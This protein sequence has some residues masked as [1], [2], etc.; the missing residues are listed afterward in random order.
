MSTVLIVDDEDSIRK[1]LHTIFNHG[2]GFDA[3]G[4][5]GSGAEAIAKTKQ[6][7]PN[8]VV[9][10]F[11]L[12]DMNGLQLARKLKAIAPELPIFMLTSDYNADLEKEA[13]SSGITAVFSKL[14]DLSTLIT[15]ARAVCG[16]Q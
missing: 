14:D 12:P 15:N 10:D 3:C 5:V 4:E 13:L 16:I 2:S 11:S 1:V 7:F 9:L 6:L 8:L